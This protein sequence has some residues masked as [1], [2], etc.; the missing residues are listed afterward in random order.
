MSEGRR[1]LPHISVD[2]KSQKLFSPPT[3]HAGI[4]SA[5]GELGFENT[6]GEGT[7]IGWNFAT[8]LIVDVQIFMHV[9]SCCFY[10]FVWPLL[11]D[12]IPQ[13]WFNS[14]HHD[15]LMDI[16]GYSPYGLND[17]QQL[18]KGLVWWV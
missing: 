3:N 5:N 16:H 2:F 18:E 6:G 17:V 15:I 4:P 7:I 12:K 1:C 13:G 11:M 9:V 8:V 14:C 10:V